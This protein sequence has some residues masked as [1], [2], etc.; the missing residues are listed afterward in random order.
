MKNLEQSTILIVD[1]NP[2]NLG[3]LFDYLSKFE[4]TVRVTQSGEAALE[5]I[6]RDRPDIIL[7]DIIMPGIDGFEV[8]RRLKAHD[9]T[10]DI[11]VIFMSALSETVDKIKGF[12]VGGVDYVTKPFQTEEVLARVTIH[13]N[14][15]NLQRSLQ[16]KNAQ[17]QQEVTKRKQVEAALQIQT[18]KLNERLKELNCLYSIFA[19][20]E[21]PDISLE[22]VLEGIVHLIPPAWQHPEIT[23]ARLILGNLDLRTKN[24]KETPWKQSSDI[25]I[26]GERVGAVE[27]GYLKKRPESDEGPFSKKEKNLLNAIAEQ[28][29]RAIERMLAQEELKKHHAHLKGLVKDTISNITTN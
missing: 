12:Y 11:P 20:I 7:L 6:Q 25:I 19:L 18:H 4:F 28:V 10:R 2:A 29:G 8:C 1:D 14:L 13:L 27:V 21:K 23:C 24:F 15:Q 17:L 5:L 16:D 22:K 9:E 26:Y 3:M